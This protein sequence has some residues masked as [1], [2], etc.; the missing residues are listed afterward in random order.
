M[1]IVADAAVAVRADMARFGS[2]L[3]AGTDAPIK[4]LGDRIKGAFSPRNIALGAAALGGLVVAGLAGAVKALIDIE[5]LNAQ[6]DAVIRSTGGAANVTR[7]QIEDAAEAAEQAT[8]IEREAVQEAQN[9]LLTF[10]NVRDEVGAGNDIFSQATES[11][12]DM[13]VAMGTD[14]RTAAMQLGKALNDP[15]KGMGQLGRAG[16]Q[17]SEDQKAMVEQLVETGDILGAQKII[18]EELETQFGGSAEAFANTTAGRVQRFQNDVGNAFES[19]IV[20]ATKVADFLG[21][22][23]DLWPFDGPKLAAEAGVTAQQTMDSYA[24]TIY[25]GGTGGPTAVADAAQFA[26]TD[27]LF[28]E[29]LAAEE[30]ANKSG[31]QVVIEYAAGLLTPQTDVERAIEAALQVIEDEMSITEELAFLS[32]QKIVLEEARGIAMQEGKDASVIAI[33]GALA[34][35]DGRMA[36]LANDA[37]D[38]GVNIAAELARGLRVGKGLLVDPAHQLSNV[39]RNIT[40]IESEPKDHSSGLYGITKWGG[41]IVRTLADGIYGELGSARG[42]AGAL[43]ASLVPSLPG[44]GMAMAAGGAGG[45]PTFILQVEGQPPYV[46]SREDVIGRWAQMSGFSD[47]SMT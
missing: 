31:H 21:T 11:V 43:A 20:G 37:Y 17:F 15:V 25:G 35:I 5:R 32:G 34:L 40:G 39:I 12:L 4:S 44:G 2:D 1:P 18:L 8:T 23:V 16:V 36:D 26:I 30:N 9:L 29:M 3:R 41:N 10:T 38:Y 14:A 7:Q 46:G 13:S 6:T 19:I 47:R 42:A 24:Q 27:P 33:D 45:G 28:A 22:E